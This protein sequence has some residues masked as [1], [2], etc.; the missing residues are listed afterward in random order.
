[1]RCSNVVVITQL[2]SSF[3]SLLLHT[4]SSA[5][6][7]E[8]SEAMT[9]QSRHEHDERWLALLNSECN[10]LV[11]KPCGDQLRVVLASIRAASN[12]DIQSKHMYDAL[13]DVR[14]RWSKD[15]STHNSRE[16][17]AC[18]YELM[19]RELLPRIRLYSANTSDAFPYVSQSVIDDVRAMRYIRS[20][21]NISHQTTWQRDGWQLLQARL[22]QYAST[23]KGS[24]A[25]AIVVNDCC[26]RGQV[27]HAVA[28]HKQAS[29]NTAAVDSSD[30]EQ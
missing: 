9:E 10:C 17:A 2:L 27:A 7:Y 21:A 14:R 1:M 25:E 8:R 24:I 20:T 6:P 11:G 28:S 19:P 4:G 26:W 30:D 18:N 3:M 16:A 5:I 29:S 15:T 23:G 12:D 13:H 22:Q